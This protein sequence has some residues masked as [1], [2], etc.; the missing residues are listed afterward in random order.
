MKISFIDESWPL[1]RFTRNNNLVE[2]R[3]DKQAEE[4]ELQF[5]VLVIPQKPHYLFN[6]RKETPLSFIVAAE[7]FAHHRKKQILLGKNAAN[8]STSDFL[9]SML[10]V[11]K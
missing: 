1:N 11:G 10:L 9:E 2:N 4:Q 3:P 8:H 7:L 5:Y 6:F